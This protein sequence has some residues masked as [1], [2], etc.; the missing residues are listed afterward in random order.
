MLHIK[1]NNTGISEPLGYILLFSLSIIV[2]GLL[3]GIAVP[4]LNE[5][6]NNKKVVEMEDTFGIL[7]SNISD[8]TWLDNTERTTTVKT[9]EYPVQSISENEIKI[10]FPSSGRQVYTTYQPIEYTNTDVNGTVIYEN[11]AVITN[12][13]TGSYMTREPNISTVNNTLILP[14]INTQ[15]VET[16]EQP[17]Q[18]YT[19]QTTKRELQLETISVGSGDPEFVIESEYPTAWTQMLDQTTSLNSCS[20]TSTGR[21]SC[22]IDGSIDTIKIRSVQITVSI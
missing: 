7:H 17:G 8:L 2:V 5:D 6:M 13:P 4:N 16:S 19:I 20:E 14:F 1:Q 3:F 12:G 11:G 9:T 15:A 10:R 18:I 21:V 22:Q